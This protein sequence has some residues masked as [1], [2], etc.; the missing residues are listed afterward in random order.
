MVKKILLGLAILLGLVVLGGFLLPDRYAISRSVTTRAPLEKVQPLLE[1]L[2]RWPEWS[3]WEKA[4]ST[5]VTTLGPVTAG[6]GASQQWTDHTG[7]GRLELNLV[8]P[9]RVEYD[10]WFADSKTPAH[11]VMSAIPAPDGALTLTW[12]IEGEMDMPGVGPYFALLAGRMIGPMFDGG[13]EALKVAAKN[14]EVFRATG[15][16]APCPQ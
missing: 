14:P 5:I 7:G 9:G 11:S 10:V 4:D 8:E 12:S 6:L 2:T 1:D 3:P 13:L 16:G 15:R